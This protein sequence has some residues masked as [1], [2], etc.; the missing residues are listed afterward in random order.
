[1]AKPSKLLNAYERMVAAEEEKQRLIPERLVTLIADKP[2]IKAVSKHS[3]ARQAFLEAAIDFCRSQKAKAPQT[4]S[5]TNAKQ[6]TRTNAQE[7][8]AP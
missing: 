2:W 5:K 3:Q 4:S 1:M 6:A 8:H 7:V